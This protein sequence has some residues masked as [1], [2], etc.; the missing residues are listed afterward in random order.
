[1]APADLVVTGLGVWCAAGTTPEELFRTALQARSPAV[2]V[3]LAG[4]PRALCRAPD[5]PIPP[6]FP[7]A[8]RLDRSAQFAL[9]AAEAASRQARLSELHSSRVAVAVGNSRGPVELWSQP[10]P[11]RVRPS[12]SAHSAI[13]S[14]S[15]ALSLAFRFAGP[16]LTLSATCAS[17]AHAIVTGASLL[18][19]DQADAVLVGGAEA[20]LTGPTLEAFAAAGILGSHPDPRLAC[21]PF[22][23]TRN[24]TTPGEGA[25]FLV[26]ETAAQARRRGLPP[27][28]RLAGFALGAE[29]HNR[30]ATRP[31]GAGLARVME[32]ALLRA[33]LSPSQVGHVNAHGTGT[34]VNDAAEAAALRHL[35]HSASRP[36][37]VTS[38]KPVTGHCF[39]A[40]AALEAVLAV[41]SLRHR[42]APPI[43]ACPHP[44]T[45][46]ELNLVLATPR[47]LTPPCVM[48]NSLG[49]W[50]NL[51]SLIFTPPA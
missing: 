16:C 7:Q 31:D 46:L 11:P 21:R 25:A 8:R 43:A 29:C 3:P 4:Q 13:A 6:A 32:T 30:V 28:A 44:D 22:D 12:Q 49:F 14:L 26:L 19:T 36:P 42:L 40:A 18:L 15:G 51:A 5:P 20:P 50:G 10:P 39:G 47:P 24:G 34:A 1:M 45:A 41:Q 23:R 38:T 33:G 37:S 9:A 27:L 2:S 35:F 17:A 48:S